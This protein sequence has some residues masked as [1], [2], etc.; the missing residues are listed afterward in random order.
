MTLKYYLL[1]LTGLILG[2][3]AEQVKKEP[4]D[5]FPMEV[6]A[7]AY[8]SFPSQTLGDP[9]IAAWGDTLIPGTKAIAVSRDLLDKGMGHNTPIR[10]EGFSD[11]FYVKDK[12]HR[13]WKNRIDIYMGSD[14]KKAKE[15][16]RRKVHISYGVK[17]ID[18]LLN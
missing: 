8:N 9:S 13:K 10:I 7:T 2:S 11:T 6:T 3:C 14:Y 18:S 17:K 12:M 5:W 15:W 16:G 1:V 4:Y